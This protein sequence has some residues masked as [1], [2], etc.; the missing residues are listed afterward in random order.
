MKPRPLIPLVASLLLAF[1]I[2]LSTSAAQAWQT[3]SPT[4]G[5]FSVELPGTPKKSDTQDDTIL[6]SINEQLTTSRYDSG[7]YSVEYQQLPSDAVMLG[8]KSDIFDDAKKGLLK[9]ASASE[10]SWTDTSIDGHPAKR[11]EYA[12]NGT[13]GKALFILVGDTFY[14]LDARGPNLSAADMDKFFESFQLD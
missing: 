6:G 5:G 1:F 9:D 10:T 4:G 8:G 13:K 3:F 2:S 12:G 7:T 11:L 14:V